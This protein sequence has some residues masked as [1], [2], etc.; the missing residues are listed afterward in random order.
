MRHFTSAI[1]ALTAEP[2]K[3]KVSVQQF[4]ARAVPAKECLQSRHLS[5]FNLVTIPKNGLVALVKI[6]HFAAP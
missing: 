1:L 6:D 5:T 3:H 2:R 4:K